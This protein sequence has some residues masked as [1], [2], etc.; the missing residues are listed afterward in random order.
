KPRHL[1]SIILTVPPSMPKPERDIFA[2]RMRQAVALV[3]KAL[4]WH[5]EDEDPDAQD[6]EGRSRAWPP[7][8]AI[9]TQWD[10]ATCAQV[11]YLFSES[12]E[13]FAGRPEDFFRALRRAHKP[14]VGKRLTVAS[15]DIGG[16][17][18]D[19]VVTDYALDEGAGANVYIV[20]Q[21]RFRDGFK[22][23]GD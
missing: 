22:V 12:Q 5:P 1:R 8:P 15:I 9:H 17:T 2:E 4:G 21:Q 18:T 3:W 23:A 19:L 20:P 10:E 11:V 6:A 14:D 16:G 13:H 7:F